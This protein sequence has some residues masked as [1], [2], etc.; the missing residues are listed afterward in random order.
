MISSTY[1][2]QREDDLPPYLP[3]PNVSIIHR[4]T[5]FTFSFIVAKEVAME[6]EQEERARQASS[7]QTQQSP[8][9]AII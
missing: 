4:C 6:I 7:K 8:V 3:G 5:S 2:L 9:S 1:N